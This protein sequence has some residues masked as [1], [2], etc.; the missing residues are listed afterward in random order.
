MDHENEFN[1]SKNGGKELCGGRKWPK[2][3]EKSRNYR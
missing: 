3:V 1:G 2:M